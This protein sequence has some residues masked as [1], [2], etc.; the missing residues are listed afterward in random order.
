MPGHGGDATYGIPTDVVADMRANFSKK[1]ASC[2]DVALFSVG[3]SVPAMVFFVIPVWIYFV[4]YGMC[5][6]WL[7]PVHVGLV[8]LCL[9]TCTH[10]CLHATAHKYRDRPWNISKPARPWCQRGALVMMPLFLQIGFVIITDVSLYSIPGLGTAT[11][12]QLLVSEHDDMF[13]LTI[14]SIVGPT[15][16]TYCT[17]VLVSI[18]TPVWLVWMDNE[19]DWRWSVVDRVHTCPMHA[20][21]MC[22]CTVC[23]PPREETAPIASEANE[24]L[25]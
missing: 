12:E 9:V 10:A 25:Q 18:I 16:I 24:I 4:L 22:S 11:F 13:S 1:R 15:A 8:V 20:M 3:Q 21:C 17:T 14:F 6:F 2:A 19:S 23:L 5:S 7:I